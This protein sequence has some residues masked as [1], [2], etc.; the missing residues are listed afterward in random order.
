M[1][2]EKLEQLASTIEKGYHT[3]DGEHVAFSMSSVY[4]D[5]DADKDV[6]FY[7][8]D[9]M[10]ASRNDIPDEI[11]ATVKH[12][13]CLIGFTMILWGNKDLLLELEKAD[14]GAEAVQNLEIEASSILNIDSQDA[15]ELFY[16]ALGRE[17]TGE[18]VS[19]VIRKYIITGEI[20]WWLVQ[21]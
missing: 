19:R 18:Q 16:G 13:A 3:F 4:H 21:R 10:F 20:D 5:F 9:E 12:S 11:K 8:R 1:N 6:L 7:S 15:H 14:N 2:I 17:T